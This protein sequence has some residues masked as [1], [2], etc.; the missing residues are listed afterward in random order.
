MKVICLV[1]ESAKHYYHPLFSTTR[2]LDVCRKIYSRV[3]SSEQNH[4]WE[5]LGA[6]RYAVRFTLA[7]AKVSRDPAHLW[8]GQP[9]WTG[10]SYSP[11]DLDWLVDYLEDI[12]SDDQEAAFDILLLLVVIKVRCS[13]AV[14]LRHA[15]LRLAH[16]AREEMVSID[17]I[18]NAE[19]RDMILTEF[20]PAILTAVCP[21]SDVTLSDNDPDRDLCYLELL[22]ALAR[23]SNWH[24]HLF[25]DHHM[26]RC[27][28]IVAKCHFEEHAFYLAGILLRIA[29]EQLS[30]T[31]LNSIT[32]QQWW[33]L[34]K[35]A[36]LHASYMIDDIHCF[37]FLP[38]LV[39]GTK[40]Y[41]HIP[42]ELDLKFFI[43]DADRVLIA[44]EGR[45]SQQG[46]GR[47]VVVA[48]KEL[49]TVASDMLEKLVS[50]KGVAGP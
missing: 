20:S 36:W 5:L 30:V 25:E 14:H 12:D 45:D 16:S 34:M 10:D 4:S 31:S 38:V 41:M 2:S 40:R 50:N 37:E 48:V 18:D 29:P 1:L 49:R 26:D 24:P 8:N 15:A 33:D 13:P 35:N 42:L 28:S 3:R 7:A 21:Q 23:N 9:F 11:E 43:K 27:I 39:E 44:L 6:L 47:G 46:E 22:F 19:L 32:G 17:V